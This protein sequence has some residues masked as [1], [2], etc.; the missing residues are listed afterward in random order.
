MGQHNVGD[1]S[2]FLKRILIPFWCVRIF[3]MAIN[4]VVYI[5][6]ISL[7]VRYKDDI[8]HFETEFGTNLSPNAVIAIWVVIMII[9]ALCLSL[10]LVAIIKRARRNLSPKF[11]LIINVIQTFVWTVLFALSFV[12]ARANA[13]S[14]A[15]A[16][17]SHSLSFVGL[18]IYA[19]IIFHKDRKGTL[20][21]APA[22]NPATGYEPHAPQPNLHYQ[23]SGAYQPYAPQTHAQGGAQYAGQAYSQDYNKPVYGQHPESHEL[24]H[25]P[26]Y[27]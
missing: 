8:S 18:L 7:V 23:Q 3:V 9:L 6:A 4:V 15:I 11:F 16:V 5:L 10:D 1:T 19:A 12:G 25:Q 2:P 26:R 17:P 13:A 20:Q 22:V 27:A 14:T 21:Y 24:S